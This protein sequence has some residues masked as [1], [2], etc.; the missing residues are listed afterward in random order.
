MWSGWLGIALYSFKLII[1]HVTGLS[2]IMI[3]VLKKA[4]G[5][6]RRRS[7]IQDSPK[8]E[9]RHCPLDTSERKRSIIL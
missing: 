8:V 1:S 5:C 6:E 2:G 3:H 7:K 4:R 9:I